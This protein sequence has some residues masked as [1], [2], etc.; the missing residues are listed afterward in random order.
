MMVVML[1]HYWKYE[2]LRSTGPR[3]L[4]EISNNEVVAELER[5]TAYLLQA[6]VPVPFT[7]L[8]FKHNTFKTFKTKRSNP[9]SLS[10]P[11]SRP[12]KKSSDPGTPQ[13]RDALRLPAPITP[14]GS[15]GDVKLVSGLSGA[16]QPATQLPQFAS[17]RRRVA[18]LRPSDQPVTGAQDFAG[19][20]SHASMDSRVDSIGRARG[21]ASGAVSFEPAEARLDRQAPRQHPVPSYDETARIALLMDNP[22][23]E[24]FDETA[25]L[26]SF[27]RMPSAPRAVSPAIL[28]HRSNSGDFEDT[29]GR[30]KAPTLRRSA[31]FQDAPIQAARELETKNS[32]NYLEPQGWLQDIM[33]NAD[34]VLASAE[35]QRLDDRLITARSNDTPR[36]LY[37]IRSSDPDDYERY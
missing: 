25:R 30:D 20:S 31:S 11:V 9:R 16:R 12:P 22:N 24:S 1:D 8:V 13:S 7:R 33:V 34:L 28:R 27:G 36:R 15:S 10:P 29:K 19:R 21:L 17:P 37:D 26:A 2:P 18:T 23:A 35:Q 3:P 32:Q 6:E 5:R 14:E 4:A